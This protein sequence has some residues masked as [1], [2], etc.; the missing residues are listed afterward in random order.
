MFRTFTAAAVLALTVATAQA[1]D[2]ATVHFGDLNLANPTDAQTLAGRVHTAAALVCVSENQDRNLVLLHYRLQRE[3]CIADVS[4]TISAKVV[5]M[6]GQA[7]K[8]AA[9]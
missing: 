1:G 9:K 6:S 5:A 7:R 3:K 8:L 2:V 4:Q